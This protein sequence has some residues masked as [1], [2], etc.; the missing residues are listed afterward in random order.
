MS[1][2]PERVYMDPDIKFPE[3]EKRYGCDIEYVRGDLVEAAVKKLGDSLV[4]AE[5][6]L[7]KAVEALQFYRSAVNLRIDCE[8]T[9]AM[10]EAHTHA[11]AFIAKIKGEQP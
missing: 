4:A 2:V 9:H 3:C 8:I 5:A 1:E 6:K 10:Q 11:E 7:A